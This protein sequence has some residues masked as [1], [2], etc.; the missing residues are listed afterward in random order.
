MEFILDKVNRLEMLTSIINDDSFVAATSLAPGAATAA[1]TVGALAEKVIQTFIPA[2]EREPILQFSGEFNLATN[3]FREGYYVILGT[4]DA[5]NPL[6]SPIPP[7]EVRN[8]ELFTDKGDRITQLSYVILAVRRAPARTRDLNAGAVWEA[9]L[10]QA[11]ELASAI[12]NDP[13]AGEEKRRS[14]WDACRDLVREAQTLLREDPSFHRWEAERIIQT[15]YR[16]CVSLV[17]KQAAEVTRSTPGGTAGALWQPDEATDR[18]FGHHPRPWCRE[19]C[20][21]AGRQP[22]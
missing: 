1:K 7:L 22:A 14:S 3:E 6:P 18:P 2:Q 19:Q 12:T 13:L 4:R 21:T 11:E 10:R 16:Q 5:E 15:V 17:L 8:G 9:K 20:Y